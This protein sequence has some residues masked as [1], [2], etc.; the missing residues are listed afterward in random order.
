MISEISKTITMPLTR[1]LPCPPSADRKAWENV[2]QALASQMVENGEAHLA[3]R[4]PVILAKDFMD[5]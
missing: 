2:P 1:F 3:R 4:P 5:F